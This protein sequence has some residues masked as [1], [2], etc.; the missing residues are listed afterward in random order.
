MNVPDIAP[1]RVCSILIQAPVQEVW[2]EITKTGSIQRP[3]YNTRLEVDLEEEE[4]DG[5]ATAIDDEARLHL[6]GR[7]LCRA[8]TLRIQAKFSRD[9]YGNIIHTINSRACQPVTVLSPALAAAV[10]PEPSSLVLLLLGLLAG[11][12]HSTRRCTNV[13]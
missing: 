6:L 13:G 2:D 3:L 1:P 10:T 4:D 11:L 5:P 7:V 8:E 12:T 9:L